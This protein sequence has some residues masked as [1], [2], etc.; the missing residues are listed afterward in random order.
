[1]SLVC[2][3]DKGIDN[4]G[5]GSDLIDYPGCNGQQRVYF[6]KAFPSVIGFWQIL[7]LFLCVSGPLSTPKPPQHHATQPAQM[8]NVPTRTVSTLK[9]CASPNTIPDPDSVTG[10]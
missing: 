7:L 10:K 9:N 3:D 2:A 6:E 8:L 5:D 1:M 4:C